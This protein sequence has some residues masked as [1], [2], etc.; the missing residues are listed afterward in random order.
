[1]HA[2]TL[3]PWGF[4]ARTVVYLLTSPSIPLTDQNDAQF[5][6]MIFGMCKRFRAF[7]FHLAVLPLNY[8]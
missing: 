8:L 6:A 1:M 2:V 3:P 7:S 4:T 5:F